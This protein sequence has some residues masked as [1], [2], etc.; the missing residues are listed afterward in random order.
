[1]INNRLKVIRYLQNRNATPEDEEDLS[2][3]SSEIFARLP[4]SY[5]CKV[6][7]IHME[8]K[9]GYIKFLLLLEC[10]KLVSKLPGLGL[11]RLHEH[12]VL[13]LYTI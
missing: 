11:I 13:S 8:R 3:C 9:H 10:E 1:M 7:I 6:L 4:N 2:F 12:A 5:L